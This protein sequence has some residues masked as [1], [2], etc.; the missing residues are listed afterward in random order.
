MPYVIGCDVG[1]QSLKGVLYDPEGCYVAEAARQYD[2]LFPHPGWAEQESSEWLRALREVVGELLARTGVAP[3]AIGCLGLASQV[4]GLVAVG[5][6]GEALRPAI[7]WMDRRGEEETAALGRRIPADEVFALTGLNLD[8]SHVAP[9]ILWLRE[10]ERAAFDRAGHLLLPGAFIV[11]HLTGEAVVDYSNASSSMLYDVRAKA[12]SPRMLDLA[13]LDAARLGR[14][15]AA[16]DVAGTLTP[17]AAAELGLTTA[18]TVVV[19]CGD[20][21]GACL[22]AGLVRP[23]LVCDITGT[24][25]P[26]AVAAERPVFDETGLVETHAHADRRLWLIE[27]PGFVSGGSVRW[28]ADNIARSGYED[29]TPGAERIPPGSEGLHFVPALSGAMTPTW[30]GAARGVFFG[31]SMKHTQHHFTR[32]VFEGCTFGFRDIVDRFD[33][34]GID[35]PEVRVV[36]GG[37]KSRLWLQMKADATGRVLRTLANPE[38]TA[39]GAAMLA[40]VAAGTFGSLDEAADAV[41]QLGDVY[42]PR[43]EC[44][45]AYD[46]AYATYRRLYAVLEREFWTRSDADAPA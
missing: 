39:I 32:A 4:D 29:M 38:A 20:E 34:L 42:E 40:G 30:N 19:G 12:W 10:H 26:V 25:E 14:I 21:H 24:A 46:E 22:G 8:S 37:A 18:T 31:I 7:I 17:A 6:S 11:H 15:A 9:K 13:G 3:A 23:G 41:V 36:G 45:P 28:F 1:S 35:C 2:M 43:P 44:R 5:P 27:N 16:D 33:G